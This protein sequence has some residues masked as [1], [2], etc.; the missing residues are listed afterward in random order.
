MNLSTADIEM[1]IEIGHYAARNQEYT[2]RRI[3]QPKFATN[4]IRRMA[5][6]GLLDVATL[7]V[8]PWKNSQRDPGPYIT[9]TLTME[10]WE[11]VREH[12]PQL[13]E[14]GYPFF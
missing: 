5:D 13:F 4:A 7:T 2:Q 10:G 3:T 12:D 1:I 11:I 8:S 9:A 6:K 14:D